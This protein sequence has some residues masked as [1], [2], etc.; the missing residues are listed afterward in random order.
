[1][2]QSRS[3]IVSILL[4]AVCQNMIMKP[5]VYIFCM[6]VQFFVHREEVG[7]KTTT[8]D[9]VL[10]TTTYPVSLPEESFSLKG[11][12]KIVVS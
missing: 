11:G 10:H 2:R 9:E 1:M 5:L 6:M 12:E 3:L 8:M 7:Q 4:V